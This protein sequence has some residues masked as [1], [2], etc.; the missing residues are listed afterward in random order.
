MPTT[1]RYAPGRSSGGRS[2]RGSPAPQ[3]SQPHG[4]A[5]LYFQ[6][7]GTTTAA[8]GR[9]STGRAPVSNTGGWGFDSLRPCE[10]WKV[11]RA[12]DPR[13]GREAGEQRGTGLTVTR[14][15]AASPDPEP[16]NGEWGP[17]GQWTASGRRRTHAPVRGRTGAV[18]CR[19][20]DPRRRRRG[21]SA[22]AHASVGQLVGPPGCR[23]GPLAGVQVRVLPGVLGH[24]EGPA[25]GRRRQP[26]RKRKARTGVRVRSSL[27][28]PGSV[29]PAG[30]DARL[31]SGRSRVQ[32][33]Y[34]ARMRCAV[35]AA[36]APMR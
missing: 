29:G 11:P 15:W 12:P 34:G 7:S 35:K 24:L 27:P 20:S 31:S 33:P 30:V 8:N 2:P 5:L 26:F 17:T 28:P 36:L 3:D 25:D 32:V 4:A 16:S 23:P 22:A 13:P 9:S 21:A 18:A 19:R 14:P 6:P 10:S 1:H